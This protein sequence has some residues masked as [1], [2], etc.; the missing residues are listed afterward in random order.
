MVAFLLGVG[1]WRLGGGMIK[2]Q[3][4]RS[5][6]AIK[7]IAAAG[8]M[9]GTGLRGELGALRHPMGHRVGG[10]GLVDQGLLQSP[11]PRLL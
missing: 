11:R 9:E 6:T 4:R 2:A 7:E 3:I 10:E 8:E 5:A 1:C